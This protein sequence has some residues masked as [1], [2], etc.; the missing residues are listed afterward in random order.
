MLHGSMTL[1]YAVVRSN[2]DKNLHVIFRAGAF[3]DLPRR[4]RCLGLVSAF[5]TAISGGASHELLRF[6]ADGAFN[7]HLSPAIV[8][9][10]EDVLLTR[11]HL[12]ATLMRTYASSSSSCSS[13]PKSPPRSL[14]G[15]SKN[16]PNGRGVGVSDLTT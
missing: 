8:R 16:R 11:K 2:A 6:A 12:R 3:D 13:S 4:I 14:M 15:T 9:E 7:L 5:L 10:T 1:Q